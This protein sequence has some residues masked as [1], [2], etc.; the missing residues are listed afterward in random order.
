MKNKT[1]PIELSL[2]ETLEKRKAGKKPVT[3]EDYV[4]IANLAE[5]IM[6]YFGNI[7]VA[8]RLN[9]LSFKIKQDAATTKKVNR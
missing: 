9:I 6:K 1:Q 8:Q 5:W 3:A 4:F 7:N 2:Y